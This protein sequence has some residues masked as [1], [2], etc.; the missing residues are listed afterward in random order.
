MANLQTDPIQSIITALQNIFMPSPFKNVVGG[1]PDTQY[2]TVDGNL[3]SLF[4]FFVGE[5]GKHLASRE[6]VHAVVKDANGTTATVYKEKLRLSYLFQLSVFAS[7]PEDR[8]NL[9]WQVK[10]YL[11]SNPQLQIGTLGAGVETAVFAF[12]GERDDQGET[13]FYQRDITFEV[14]ARVLDAQTAV[15]IATTV[16]LNNNT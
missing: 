6:N 16:T 9:G 7:T 15:P 3:P 4:I 10:Q 1:W 13:K 2:F 11:V 8:S 14:S 12:K 5:T